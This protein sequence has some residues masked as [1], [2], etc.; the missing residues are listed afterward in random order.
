VSAKVVSTALTHYSLTRFYEDVAGTTRLNGA[1]TA[2]DMATAFGLY[3]GIAP[4]PPNQPPVAAFTSSCTNLACT[5]DGSGSSDPDGT[6]A[7]YAWN[8]GD[9]TTGTGVAPGHTYAAD[10]TYPVALT[11]TDNNGAANSV[12]HNVTVTSAPP[13]NQ[14]PIAAFTSSCTDLACTFDGSGSSDLDGTIASY[15]WNFGDGATGTG[16]APS[17]TYAVGGTYSVVL[18]VTD[19]GGATNS[20]THDVTV[21]APPPP[22][23]TLLLDEHFDGTDLDP[24]IWRKYAEGVPAC[25]SGN[26]GH[27]LRCADAV[28]VANGEAV[29]TAQM[30]NGVLHSGAFTVRSTSGLYLQYG[31][32]EADIKTDADPVNVMSAVALTWPTDNNSCNGGENDWYETGAQRLNFKSFIHYG[33]GS[34]VYVIHAVDPTAWHH[35]TMEWEPNRLAIYVD[36]VLDKEWT[37]PAIIPD[38]LHRDTFQYDATANDLGAEVTKMH[39]DNVR[40]WKLNP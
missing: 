8:F 17:H 2:P 24:A 20:I 32:Y 31:K 3:P 39:I 11:V 15:G 40:I 22:K 27:G 13:T 30:V 38:Y 21:T 7:S 4:P 26:G 10:G 16:V 33:C 5:F 35:V 6:I 19:N 12:T 14:P 28:T 36:G 1:A 29:I 37:D 18:T 34:Q 9:G 23:W 25:W